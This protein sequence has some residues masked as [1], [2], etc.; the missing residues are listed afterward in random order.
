[1]VPLLHFC[2]IWSTPCI[3]KPALMLMISTMWI[4]WNAKLTN[5]CTYFKIIVPI[6]KWI[7]DRHNWIKPIFNSFGNRYNSFG[8]RYNSFGDGYNGLEHRYKWFEE[9]TVYFNLVLR[10]ILSEKIWLVG[11]VPC[12]NGV[13]VQLNSHFNSSGQINKSV[14][15]IDDILGWN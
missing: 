10:R 1:M 5:I 8:D 14:G 4:L 15:I 6:S 2:I 13:C 9:Y 12:P 11:R 3:Y 7:K